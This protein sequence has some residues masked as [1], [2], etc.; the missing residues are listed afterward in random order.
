[1]FSYICWAVPT[2]VPVNQ[3]F[4]VHTGMGM[5]VLTFDWTQISWIGS[6]LM[7]EFLVPLLFFRWVLCSMALFFFCL[8]S[9][10]ITSLDANV[11][12][13]LVPWWAQVHIFV[14][15]V[16][17]Y[18]IL[19]PILYYTNVRH[20]ILTPINLILSQ[21]LGSRLLPHLWKRTF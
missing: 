2:N 15:F 1:M 19:T 9:L 17:F 3:L 8:R 4:G 16:M 7:G 18:W 21:V 5:G 14:G 13:F 6:P 11:V 10:A 12:I 20:L